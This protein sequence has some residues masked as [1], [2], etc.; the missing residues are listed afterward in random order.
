MGLVVQAL[1]FG[2]VHLTPDNGLGNVGTF[3]IIT[4]VGLG[5]GAIRLVSKR[6]PPGMFTHAG[7]NAIIVTIAMFGPDLETRSCTSSGSGVGVSSRRRSGRSRAG[8]PRTRR[9]R[10]PSAR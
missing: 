10:P 2:S 8:G 9:S 5:L 4:A 1:L 3:V 7:Y 6:L